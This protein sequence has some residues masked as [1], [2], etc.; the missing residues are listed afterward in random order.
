MTSAA[1]HRNATWLAIA[2]LVVGFLV[3]HGLSRATVDLEI[4]RIGERT[5][6][7]WLT[8]TLFAAAALSAAA[9]AAMQRGGARRPWVAAAVLMVALSLDEVATLHESIEEEGGS[10]LSLFLIQPLIALVVIAL[11][12]RLSRD[13]GR[14]E[15]LWMVFAAVVLAVAQVGSMVDS[16]V[17]LPHVLHEGWRSAEELLEMLVPA[18]LLA[19]TVPAP[20]QRVAGALRP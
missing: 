12:V 6:W 1:R 3:L 8:S 4:L 7:T 19:A 17:E 2:L 20:W 15:R 5:V 16:E 18:F 13:L 9:F 10:Q 11:L 14:D